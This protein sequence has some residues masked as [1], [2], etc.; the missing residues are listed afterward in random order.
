MAVSV[1]LGVLARDGDDL[2]PTS[3][4]DVE[5]LQSSVK[6]KRAQLEK[7]RRQRVSREQGLTNEITAAQLQAEEARLDAEIAAEKSASTPSAV[8]EGASTPLAQAKEQ[9][10]NAVAAQKN[11]EALEAADSAA[12]DAA[13]K[14]EKES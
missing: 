14:T 4:K 7:A 13:N 10:E 3:D 11:A 8:R 6:K 2:V 12:K 5:T 9:M 1:H